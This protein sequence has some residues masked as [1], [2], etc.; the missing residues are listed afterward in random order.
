MAS[1]APRTVVA[2]QTETHRATGIK[3]MTL[4]PAELV[5]EVIRTLPNTVRGPLSVQQLF[6][7]QLRSFAR[8]FNP[9]HDQNDAPLRWMELTGDKGLHAETGWLDV[10]HDSDSISE[11]HILGIDVDV[12]RPLVEVLKAFT[13]TPEHVFFMTWEGY[14][15]IDHDL[16]SATKVTIIF[17]RTMLILEG[18]LEDAMQSVDDW[19]K[20]RTAQWWIPEDG[21]WIVG[22]D[23]YGAS[24]YVAGS[25]EA[26]AA[27]IA[28]PLLEAIPVPGSARVIA[29]EL[30]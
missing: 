28:S 5:P 17:N 29:E 1:T 15:G 27:V 18:Q 25:A 4:R 24:T 12:A 19:D 11:P 9:A 3:R 20:S 14:T 13:G 2:T 26:V 10:A 23:I 21:A 30:D 22:N 7:P 16:S 8:I 6:P